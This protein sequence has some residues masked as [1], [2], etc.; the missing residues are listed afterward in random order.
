MPRGPLPCFGGQYA[1]SSKDSFARPYACELY[2]PRSRQRFA[3]AEPARQA[4][5]AA[6]Q[7]QEPVYKSGRGG[8]KNPRLIHNVSPE[9][10]DKA[11]RAKIEGTVALTFVV[12]LSGNPT[13]IK[14]TQ[15]LGSGLDE[16]AIE[17]VRQWR[18]DP[19]TKDGKPV[20]VQLAA[21]VSFHL[22]K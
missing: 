18:F 17:A 1:D 6:D 13:M 10:S 22:Y 12:D 3:C 14:V 5:K 15:G 9:Y 21:E 2:G 16:K 20:A 19:G 4:D 8:V 7:S 11:R